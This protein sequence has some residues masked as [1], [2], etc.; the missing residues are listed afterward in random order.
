MTG[1]K[2]GSIRPTVQLYIKKAHTFV[3]SGKLPSTSVTFPLIRQTS[4]FPKLWT[5][6]W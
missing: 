2:T 1:F 4:L 3:A 5:P 6:V